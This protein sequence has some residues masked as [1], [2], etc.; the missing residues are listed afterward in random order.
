MN[1][2]IL[3]G[4]LALV[5]LVACACGYRASARPTLKIGLVAPFEGLYRPL[6]YDALYGVRLAVEERN[7]LGG[8]GGHLVELVALSD[9]QDPLWAAQRAREMSE[10]PDVVAVIGH[11]S[12]ETTRAAIPFYRETGLPL[13]VP[14]SGTDTLMDSGH[15]R[16]FWLVA[17]DET[18]GSAAAR[19][20]VLER[21]ADSVAMAGGEDSLLEPFV[22]TCSALGA[23]V[24]V[25]EGQGAQDL[26]PGTGSPQHDLLL[27]SM[28]GPEAAELLVELRREG[29]EVPVLGG[30]DLDTPQFAQIAGEAARGTMYLSYAP[31]VGGSAFAEAFRARWGMAPSSQATLAYEAARV[32]LDALDRCIAVHGEPT[33]QAVAEAL[34]ETTDYPGLT[35]RI[36]FDERGQALDRQV[37]LYQLV[38][39]AYPG[40]MVPCLA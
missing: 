11:L 3:S 30:T 9:D 12:D 7:E 29:C 16:V 36:T 35:G 6:G 33:R 21:G 37:Y 40:Q 38:E 34:A 19:Y 23:E 28:E 24:W 20:A 22:A 31:P 14:C 4:A 32:L 2:P 27:L 13:V 18:V 10:D 26:I 1:K 25:A 8:V 39:P 5:A 15:E 17:D